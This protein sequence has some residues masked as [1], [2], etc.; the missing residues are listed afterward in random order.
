MICSGCEIWEEY[1]RLK[2]ENS[3]LKKENEELKQKLQ[4]YEN[5]NVPPS[6]RRGYPT[7]PRS[8]S[9]RRFPGRPKGYP[10]KTRPTPKPDVV[11][12]P[13]WK[14]CERCGALLGPPSH[15]NHNTVEEISNPSPKVV[16]DFLEFGGECGWCGTYNVARHPDCPPDGRFGKNVLVQTTLMKFEDRL[17]HKKVCETLDRVYGL[18]VT[19]ATVLDITRRVSEWLKPMYEEICRRIRG[20]RVVYIDETGHYVDGEKHWLWIFTTETETFIVIRKRRSESVLEEVLGK[21]FRGFIGCDGWRSYPTFT[22]NIQRDWAHLLREAKW[23]AEHVPRA[24][25]LSKALHKL[26]DDLKHDLEDRP[27]PEER[28]RLARNAKRRLKRWIN[29]RYRNPEIKRFVAKIRNGFDHWFTF[30]T[31]PGIEPTNNRAERALREH[32]VQ[33]KII[34]TFRNG[35]GTSIY[36]TIMTLLATWKQRGLNLSEMLAESLTQEWARRAQS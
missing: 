29:K 21:N 8:N 17:P 12:V 9:G 6:R 34:G 15:V 20:A 7:R 18:S 19:P 28:A 30:V 3:E 14:E 31:H 22:K 35:K 1:Q 26:Y 5:P 11:K 2:A 33:R 16:I 13:E 23:L 10:G 32:V 4:I 25:R 36:E 27:P 24:E